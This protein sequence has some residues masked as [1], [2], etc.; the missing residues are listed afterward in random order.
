MSV[1]TLEKYCDND[2]YL[3]MNT[4]K[5]FKTSDILVV[6]INNNAISITQKNN[7]ID[8]LYNFYCKMSEECNFT[9][10]YI[11]ST[12][13]NIH[14]LETTGDCFFL[15]IFQQKYNYCTYNSNI[16]I[17]D[18][19]LVDIILK[20]KEKEHID[21][22]KL[23]VL[24]TLD[25]KI[26]KVQY[27]F[28]DLSTLEIVPTLELRSVSEKLYCNNFNNITKLLQYMY[29]LYIVN[30]TSQSQFIMMFFE[31]YMKIINDNIT[32][33]NQHF[34]TIINI[35]KKW[36]HVCMFK[37]KKDDNN[38]ETNEILIN[39]CKNIDASHISHKK[40]I[41][42]MNS[43]KMN[44][45]VDKFNE[46]IKH[47]SV[48]LLKLMEDIDEVDI[49]KSIMFFNSQ[50]SLSNWKD[51]LEE[52][53]CL[54]ILL[55]INVP[56]FCRNG[57]S[58]NMIDICETTLSLISV[59]DFIN[60]ICSKTNTTFTHDVNN[61]LL[62]NDVVLG[63]GNIVL[64]LYINK[65]HWTMCKEYIPIVLGLLIANNISLYSEIM[66]NVYYSVL[67]EYTKNM[68]SQKNA[69][70]SHNWIM[71]W[72]GIYRTCFQISLEKRYH[73]GF[74]KYINTLDTNK[75]NGQFNVLFGQMLSIG[76]INIDVINKIFN[77]HVTNLI[78]DY[79]NMNIQ[80]KNLF[81]QMLKNNDDNQLKKD[82]ILIY[83]ALNI[84][85]IID[86]YTCILFGIKLIIFIK[87]QNKG[88]LNFVKEI[89]EN[90]GVID[91]EYIEKIFGF[92]TELKNSTVIKY[93]DTIIPFNIN[94]MISY[95]KNDINLLQ[96]T[97]I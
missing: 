55:K 87:N 47:A 11:I 78:V 64:P 88:L 25:K 12:N 97:N 1:V 52:S 42:M 17:S 81:V 14:V 90:Y 72:I 77:C 27:K 69:K 2:D 30:K 76:Y 21:N 95:L 45:N 23:Y 7:K 38:H 19:E 3:F 60:I 34:Y 24:G 31:Q 59:S 62:M 46:N 63:S 9:N 33:I 67:F 4:T 39:F 82:M 50:Y 54:G 92:C 94:E 70:W 43:L 84:N 36:L 79:L 86:E 49:E 91:N 5:Q 44:S 53:S 18:D 80:F 68:F 40:Y 93:T 74:E 8:Q 83:N 61:S 15:A 66:I 35:M 6:L 26:K 41:K 10:I 85:I 32:I 28:I 71:I 37:L 73:K 96:N 13:P 22:V 57:T 65:F 48:K 75:I 29:E 51:E 58:I 20:I 56:N 16:K 89:D